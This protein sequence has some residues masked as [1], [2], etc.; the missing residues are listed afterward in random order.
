MKQKE[1]R[2]YYETLDIDAHAS[3]RE[4]ALAYRRIY[5]F[6]S[7][8][9]LA[10][11]NIRDPNEIEELK[12]EIDEAFWVLGD[13]KRRSG[14]DAHLASA[15]AVQESPDA[16]C[17]LEESPK[18]SFADPM[19]LPTI[20]DGLFLKNTRES[21]RL[22][23]EKIAQLTKIGRHHLVAIES[24]EFS[25]LPAEI[26]VRGFVQQMARVLG[27]DPALTS[28]G[29]ISTFRGQRVRG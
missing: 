27:L 3:D 14:Y 21:Q 6:L 19:P 18:V 9:T 2:S 7:P 24:N 15:H 26:Y 29:F 12:R 16:V 17:A 10:C 4:V 23:L 25:A 8:E 5:G 20:I 22:S 11:Y 28:K 13:A 1:K